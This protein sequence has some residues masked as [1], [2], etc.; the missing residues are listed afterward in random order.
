M[1]SHVPSTSIFG[2]AS[3]AAEEEVKHKLMYYLGAYE[4]HFHEFANENQDWL[5]KVRKMIEEP[6]PAPESVHM[7][8]A[9]PEEMKEEMMRVMTKRFTRAL[10]KCAKWDPNSCHLDTVLDVV[11]FLHMCGVRSVEKR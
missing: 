3:T 7:A 5:E 6:A 11:R 8:E 9:D 1:S 10:R 4:Q 2:R